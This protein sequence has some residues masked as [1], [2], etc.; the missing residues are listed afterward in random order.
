MYLCVRRAGAEGGERLVGGS[1]KIQ[2]RRNA[3]DNLKAVNSG[4]CRGRL[5]R[6]SRPGRISARVCVRVY[7]VIFNSADFSLALPAAPSL[8]GAR[9]SSAR[10]LGPSRA[11]GIARRGAG[12]A[13]SERVNKSA[14][15]SPGGSES[16]SLISISGMHHIR[17]PRERAGGGR[18]SARA[19]HRFRSGL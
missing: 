14:A 8:S 10:P 17:P 5:L 1:S 2:D 13:A 12:G 3:A 7:M 18:V 15:E 19:F 6:P 4:Q 11:R 9:P 16:A